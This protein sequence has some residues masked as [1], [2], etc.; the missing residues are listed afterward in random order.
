MV[1]SPTATSPAPINPPTTA[2]QSQPTRP[3]VGSPCRLPH[4]AQ[5]QHRSNSQV[6]ATSTRR[7]PPDPRPPPPSMA[8]SGPMR[9]SYSSGAASANPIGSHSQADIGDVRVPHGSGRAAYTGCL[10]LVALCLVHGV[11]GSLDQVFRVGLARGRRLSNAGADGYGFA[12]HDNGDRQSVG[13]ALGRVVDVVV[14]GVGDHDDEL[15][16]AEAAYQVVGGLAGA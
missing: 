11:V 10:R 12:V 2:W 6:L 14:G 15:V 16:A 7:R 1:G 5:D 3:P 9:Q 4:V 8:V 13:H